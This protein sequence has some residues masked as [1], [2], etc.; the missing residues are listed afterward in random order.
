[1]TRDRL[2][3]ALAFLVPALAAT[4]APMSTVDLAYNVR[5]GEL[6]LAAGTV[7]R[8][9]PFTFTA[10]GAPWLNQQWGAGVLFA[11]VHGTGG[12]G[13]LVVLRLLLV[14]ASVGLLAVA[15]RRWLGWRAATQLA[16][17]GFLVAIASLGLRA[18]L[19][20]IALFAAT[21]AILAW[22]D[23]RPTL[24]LAIPLLVLAWANLHG[25]FFLGPAAVA[26]TLA[27]DLLARRP[28]MR[29]LAAVLAASLA[30][31]LV[32]PFGAA[33][34]AY[35]LGI[36]TNPEI[37]RLITEWQRT[38]PLTLTGALFYA[39]LAGAL[40]VLL[41]ARRQGGLPGWPTLAW[42]GGLAFLGAYAQRGIA[43]WAVGAPV[44]LAPLLAA[45][46]ATTSAAWARLGAEPAGP[47][48]EPA[49]PRV[50][51]AAPRAE[52]A[53]FRRL[54]AGLVLALAAAL[55]ALQPLW[56]EGD[57]LTGPPGLLGEA[58]AGLARALADV[59]DGSDRA[60]VP[61][62]WASWFIWAA[63]GV[64]V[65]VDSRVEV[66]PASAWA[67]Y[68]TIVEGGPAALATLDRLAA[69]V[70]VVDSATQ[71]RLGVTLRGIGSG[72]RLH[73]EDSDGALFVR[74]PGTP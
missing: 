12:W 1:M 55:V 19:L 37:T 36:A 61:Q 64:P 26:V 6:M 50:E 34:W 44:A 57:P 24:T 39:S 28:G 22:R 23:R 54:N 67:D 48:V 4:I 49:R 53:A 13:G 47:R 66:V 58:P 74:K 31:T 14:A 9:D 45:I 65:M 27:D 3:M 56:R 41:A 15:V 18:Q 40:L 21:L 17:A 43:W 38:S 69:T 46:L 25:S 5:A 33:V 51:Q 68:L 10:A 71:E 2:W 70:V 30:A 32:N 16:L 73:H 60:V 29:R 35:A 59:A 11:A 62:P 8:E 7:V 42:L 52:R 20:G 63:P 72:W